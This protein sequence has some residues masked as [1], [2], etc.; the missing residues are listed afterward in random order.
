MG[1]A[2][3]RLVDSG[4]DAT[5]DADQ[6]VR[7]GGSIV[8]SDEPALA[9]KAYIGGAAG[10]ARVLPGVSGQ[11]QTVSGMFALLGP[12]AEAEAVT[13]ADRRT[14]LT[15]PVHGVYRVTDAKPLAPHGAVL[16]YLLT[17]VRP[18]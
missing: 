13:G 18:Q 1:A 17:L 7:S 14:R 8:R 10:Q 5:L 2:I 4:V 3:R 12:E 6:L 11:L 16:G 15:S 9:V